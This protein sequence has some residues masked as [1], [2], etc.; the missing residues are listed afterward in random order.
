M[1]IKTQTSP[2]QKRMMIAGLASLILGAILF[3]CWYG[4]AFNG[5]NPSKPLNAAKTTLPGV[6]SPEAEPN[7]ENGSKKRNRLG[8]DE[9]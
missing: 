9:P 5:T 2:A 1:T 7:S 4:G 8:G 3:L 6:N